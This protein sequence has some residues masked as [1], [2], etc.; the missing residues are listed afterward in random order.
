MLILIECQ[1][2][3]TAGSAPLCFEFPPRFVKLR[4]VSFT[5]RFQPTAT[6]KFYDPAQLIPVKPGSMTLADID[7]H[8]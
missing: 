8:A 2:R 6:D 5:R 3:R 1:Q 4:L 7:D